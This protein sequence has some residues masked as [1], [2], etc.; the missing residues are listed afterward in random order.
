MDGNTP[1]NTQSIQASP[2]EPKVKIKPISEK[3]SQKKLSKKTKTTLIVSVLLFIILGIGGYFIWDSINNKH[4]KNYENAL[5]SAQNSYSNHNYADAL[6][7]LN[8]AVEMYP[9]RSAAYQLTAKILVEKGLVSKAAEVITSA[10]PVFDSSDLAESWGMIGEYYYDNGDYE[11]AR[12]ALGNSY[13]AKKTSDY[14]DLYAKSLWNTNKL[15]KETDKVVS[16]ASQTV[17]DIWNSY[18]DILDD[19]EA[20]LFDTAKSATTFVNS[21]YP[22]LAISLFDNK[23]FDYDEY[24]EA[25]YI[26]GKAY[27]DLGEY[28]KALPYLQSALTLGSKDAG[29]EA[30]SARTN[31]QLNNIDAA[32]NSYD[33][34][35]SFANDSDVYGLM[36]EYLD[37]LIDEGMYIKAGIQLEMYADSTELDWQYLLFKLGYYS[38]DEESADSW[39]Q[40]IDAQLPDSDWKYWH[41][42]YLVK[43]ENLISEKDYDGAE[44]LLAQFEDADKY[45]PYVPYYRGVIAVD[46]EQSNKAKDYF[47]TAIDYDMEGSVSSAAKEAMSGL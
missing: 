5:V 16:N 38:G 13:D 2:L 22:Y 19:E 23:E 8:E 32:T 15:D 45:D 39:F 47:N 42:F 21:G 9:K 12:V 1:N 46:R 43:L 35:L 26:L 27:Y 4:I 25:Q 17:Q 7:Y 18:N 36:E 34:A 33:R 44:E 28:V 24:W 29:L 30:I 3:K 37:V 11:N 40:K 31:Y 14:T 41:A 20:T 6:D 10:Q